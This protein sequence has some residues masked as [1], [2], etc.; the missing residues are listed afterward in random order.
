MDVARG[1]GDKR[2]WATQV[3]NVGD[4]AECGDVQAWDVNQLVNMVGTK[5]VQLLKIDIERSE[6]ALFGDT[7]KTW[8]PRVRNICIE[9]HG[10]DLPR[11]ILLSVAKFL[12]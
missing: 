3:L 12:L 1:C 5:T 9:L 4:R 7:A 10:P 8:L 11:G 2:G 6:L